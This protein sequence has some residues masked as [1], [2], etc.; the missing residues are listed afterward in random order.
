MPL[1]KLQMENW[2]CAIEHE[3]DFVSKRN[4]NHDVIFNL[5][6]LFYGCALQI[7]VERG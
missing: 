5:L 7:V 1:D 2:W 6:L 3:N 4:V